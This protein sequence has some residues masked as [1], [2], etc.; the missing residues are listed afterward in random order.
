[1]LVNCA[2]PIAV[3]SSMFSSSCVTACRLFFGRDLPAPNRCKEVDEITVRIAEQ[4]RSIAPR[5]IG[6]LKHEFPD[7]LSQANALEID[8]VDL[9]VEN[10]RSIRPCLRG[11]RSIR[12]H[13]LL[14]RDC[15]RGSA[16]HELDISV[17]QESRGDSGHLAIEVRQG[18]YVGGNDS[19][20]RQF[21]GSS[22]LAGG[23]LVGIRPLC[24]QI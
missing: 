18:A 9:K 20:E 3:F 6:G 15:Q 12:V 14:A 5:L 2:S 1:M 23:R 7:Q 10:Y 4:H 17:T 24:C 11:P 8:V 22:F 16:G 19:S 13:S 21:H